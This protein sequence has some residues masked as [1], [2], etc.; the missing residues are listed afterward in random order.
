MRQVET[1]GL[2]L[3]FSTNLAIPRFQQLSKTFRIKAHLFRVPNGAPNAAGPPD[4][5]SCLSSA[6][7]LL[8][9]PSH[10]VIFPGYRLPGPSFRCAHS[11]SFPIPSFSPQS[12]DSQALV[13]MSPPSPGLS[14]PNPP[15]LPAWVKRPFSISPLTLPYSARSCLGHLLVFLHGSRGPGLPEGRDRVSFTLWSSTPALCS[16]HGRI[17]ASSGPG[18]SC[19]AF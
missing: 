11:L 10:L 7:P 6:L 17:S 4:P 8:Q 15:H 16:A 14:W 2:T 5:L 3:H 9:S 19:S 13:S 18:I 1:E 12:V